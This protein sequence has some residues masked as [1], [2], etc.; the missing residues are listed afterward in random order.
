MSQRFQID[1][2]FDLDSDADVRLQVNELVN[3]YLKARNEQYRLAGYDPE[4]I[5]AR[6]QMT[7]FPWGFE[8]LA[9]FHT[10]PLRQKEIAE[11]FSVSP[12]RVGKQIRKLYRSLCLTRPKK[13]PGPTPRGLAGGRKSGQVLASLGPEERDKIAR[14]AGKLGGVA[15]AQA[16]T[17]EERQTSARKAARARWDKS[18]RD[19]EPSGE[20]GGEG[21]RIDNASS[22]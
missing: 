14:N 16:M 2:R 12:D 22:S 15:R 10:T 8:A 4:E 21:R 1:R 3:A 5:E 6:Y 18:R 20:A 19:R 9:L 13:P 7:E 11:R 17:P